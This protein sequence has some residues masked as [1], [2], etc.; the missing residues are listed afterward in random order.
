MNQ[1]VAA[2]RAAFPYWSTLTGAERAKY[3]DALAEAVK[4]HKPELAELE[5]RDSGKPLPEALWDLDDVSGTY[6]YYAGLARE[7]D[8]KQYEEVTDLPPGGDYKASLRYEAVGVVA[9]IV[10]WNYP[11]LMATWKLAPALAA[12]CTVVLKPSEVT[13]LTAL[14]LALVLQEVGLPPGVINIVTGGPESGAILSN[15]PDI[16][17]ITFTGSVPT[18]IKIMTAGTSLG[19]SLPPASTYSLVFFL[20]SPTYTTSRALLNSFSCLSTAAKGI[21]NVTLELGGKSP[22]IVFDS[23]DLVRTVEWVMFGCFWTN[24]QICSATSRLLVQDTL[25]D[26]FIAKLVEETNKI[27][28]G[29]PLAE[30]VKMGPVVNSTQHDKVRGF[31]ERAR[32]EGATVAAG[33]E[34]PADCPRG[35]FI[36]PTILTDVQPSFEVW[37]TEIFGP[38][39]SVMRFSTEEE[40]IRL[41]NDSEYGLAGAVFSGEEAQLNRVTEQLRCGCVW[42]NCS[43]PCF[44]Q[45][46][47]GGMKRSGLGRDLGREGFKSYLEVKQVVTHI[48]AEPLGWY[49]VSKL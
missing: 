32:A 3:L 20:L 31:I 39:L 5:S 9:A 38:V 34:R 45:L 35:Y 30:G 24:G 27:Q 6:T 29:N 22:A 33:G 11:L 46:P 2:A 19:W 48:T 17:K 4:R 43:Q 16:D 25:Y 37:R 18:G 8:G 26:R 15:H 12:G 41:A 7:L 49:N 36:R 42:R 10:P 23:C 14:Q 44:S 47:W 1:A 28:V 21:K 13:P 40:A